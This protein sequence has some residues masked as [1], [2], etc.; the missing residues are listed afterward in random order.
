MDKIWLRVRV[1]EC[2][3][4]KIWLT[5]RVMGMIHHKCTKLRGTLD[6]VGIKEGS[7]AVCPSI[8]EGGKYHL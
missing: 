4:T 8:K 7:L 3:I 2:A 1:T 6:S 5:A